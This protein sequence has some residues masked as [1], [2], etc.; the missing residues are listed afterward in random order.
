MDSLDK[1]TDFRGTG[2]VW[3]KTSRKW[4]ESEKNVTVSG[5]HEAVS[6]VDKDDS[7]VVFAAISVAPTTQRRIPSRH[8]RVRI[9][10]EGR[11]LLS[12]PNS[13]SMWLWLL[14]IHFDMLS[15]SWNL[16]NELIHNTNYSFMAEKILCNWFECVF[17]DHFLSNESTFLNLQARRLLFD[18]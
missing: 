12:L 17:D 15:Y 5:V 8:G 10:R 3:D 4:S 7:D 14:I 2:S 13:I 11:F 6:V 1:R 18:N 9:R 16:I